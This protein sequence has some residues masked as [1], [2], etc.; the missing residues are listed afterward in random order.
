MLQYGLLPADQGAVYTHNKKSNC[1]HVPHEFE[2]VEDRGCRHHFVESL[3]P[4]ALG[5]ILGGFQA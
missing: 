1:T 2:A 4:G 5:K 3:V